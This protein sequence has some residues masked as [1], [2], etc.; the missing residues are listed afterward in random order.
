MRLTDNENTVLAGFNSSA[1]SFWDG[2]VVAGSDS[3]TWS[4]VFILEMANVLD[5]P[6]KSARGVFSSLVKKGIITSTHH[7][8]D[9]S[10]EADEWVELTTLGIQAIDD[11]KFEEDL[12]EF[13][14]EVKPVKVAKVDT[15][16]KSSS[17][18]FSHAN[19]DHETSGREGKIARAKCR[20]EH[21]AKAEELAAK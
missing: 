17:K 13:E 16:V 11:L 4:S 7:E 2:G 20:R 8:A 9:G 15:T 1:Y 19:C 3:G 21:A 12:A 18:R 5:K 6:T 14:E 10:Q